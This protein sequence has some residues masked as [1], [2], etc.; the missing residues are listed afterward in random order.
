MPLKVLLR[1]IIVAAIL[2]LIGVSV[3]LALLSVGMMHLQFRDDATALADSIARSI[4]LNL[5]HQIK[6]LQMVAG[7]QASRGKGLQEFYEFA[8]TFRRHFPGHVILADM[9]GQM[10]FNTRVELG[11]PLPLLPKPAGISAVQTLRDTGKPA[12]GDTFIG[13]LSK[14][15]LVAIAVPVFDEKKQTGFLLSIFDAAEIGPFLTDIAVPADWNIGI[16][17]SR[18]NVVSA[19]NAKAFTSRDRGQEQFIMSRKLAVAPWSVDVT[20]PRAYFLNPVLIQALA[21]VG[22]ILFG[23]I[24]AMTVSRRFAHKINTEIAELSRPPEAGNPPITIAEISNVRKA[25]EEKDDTINKYVHQLEFSFQST[26]DVI[27]NIMD[28]R[29]PYTSGHERRVGLISRAIGEEMGLPEDRL[30]GLEVIGKIHDIGKISIPS[31]I[32]AM[33]RRLTQYEFELI[34]HHATSG[35]QIVK[36]IVSPWPIAEV[37]LQHHERLDGTGYPRALKGDEIL[38]ES[39]ILMVADTVE[40]MS[41]HRPYRPALGTAAALDAIKSG[42]GKTFDPEVVTACVRLFTDKGYQIP[43]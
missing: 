19:L 37:I 34:K 21:L 29:D 3:A 6:T 22:T 42:S 23:A 41:S 25:L 1:K 32:L 15:R 20:A 2:P 27:S 8:Q 5:Q 17:D 10:L 13:P 14:T 33:P 26:V 35:H 16:L 39:R 12:V 18:R 11:T 43:T 9:S 28:E 36:D 30:Q 40:A 4:D 38:M 7:S 31:E 24:L